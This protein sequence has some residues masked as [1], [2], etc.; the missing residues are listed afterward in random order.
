MLILSHLLEFTSF[1]SFLNGNSY[2]NCH[3]NHRV[4]TSADETHHLYVSRYGRR[5][6]ELSV[7]MHTSKSIGHT[8]GSR[9]CCHVVRVK[10]TS[11]TTTG[12]Y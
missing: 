3:T 6:C 8:V 7:R 1:S 9:T 11:C 12:C 2:C 10:C 4:V 5:S